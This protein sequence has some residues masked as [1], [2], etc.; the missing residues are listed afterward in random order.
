MGGL[1]QEMPGPF[2]KTYSVST[3]GQAVAEGIEQRR[4]WVVVPG[5]VK[6]ILVLRTALAPLIDR[7]SYD[8]AAEADEMFQR[9]VA[10]RGVEAAS[11]PV[12]AGGEAVARERETA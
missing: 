7:S 1:R 9:D 6:A 2:A 4:R 5:W 8:R 3:V 12:G 11:A 10:D